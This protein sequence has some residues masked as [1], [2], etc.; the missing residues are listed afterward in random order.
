MGSISKIALKQRSTP[1]E[2]ERLAECIERGPRLADYASTFQS[3]VMENG[4][5]SF[6]LMDGE[7]IWNH[8]FFL[9]IPTPRVLYV[10]EMVR[11]PCLFLSFR[12]H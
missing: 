7:R 10:R 1:S 6:D 4:I 8:L 12:E 2:E 11:N 5:L 9:L 3:S